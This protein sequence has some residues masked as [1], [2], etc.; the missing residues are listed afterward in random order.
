MFNDDIT[1][2]EVLQL[3]EPNFETGKLCWK[4]RRGGPAIAGGEVG[5]IVGSYLKVKLKGKSYPV[6]RIIWLLA[7]GEH[8]DRF[9]DHING[10]RLDNRLCNLRLV[11]KAENAK[12]RRTTKTSTSGLNGVVWA[13][14]RKKWRAFIRWDNRLEHLGTHDDFFEAVCARK[15]AEVRYA[16]GT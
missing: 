15:S 12:N 14:D 13:S 7:T 8:P 16:Y 10:N 3:I 11:T 9:V 6:H 5:S 2:E 1:R 4:V